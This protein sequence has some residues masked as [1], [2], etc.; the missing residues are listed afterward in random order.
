M[1]VIVALTVAVSGTAAA[2]D[3]GFKPALLPITVLGAGALMARRRWP[4][5][6]LAVVTALG[7]VTVALY[8]VAAGF[9][10]G[11]A[12]AVY[13]VAVARPVRVAWT[14]LAASTAPLGIAVLVRAESRDRIPALTSLGVML[15]AAIAIGISVRNRRLHLTE[16]VERGNALA[17]ESEQRSQLATAAERARIS[18]E[19]HDV[20]AHSLSVM[21]ALADGASA[22]LEKAPAAASAALE[23]LSETGRAALADMRRVLGVL[24]DG[25]A[26]FDPAPGGPDLD[27]LVQS[28]RDA[29]MPVRLQVS[30]TSLPTDTG[31][32]LAVYRIVQ[33]SLTNALRHSG[34]SGP[35]TAVVAH[36]PGTV[37]IE[38]TSPNAPADDSAGP[39][40]ATASVIRSTPTGGR[41][42]IGMRERA[43]IYGGAVDAGP[44]S[45]GWRVHADLHWDE[46]GT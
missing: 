16:L 39:S 32:Q 21:V 29:G 8:S 3:G 2:F 46:E 40:S 11:V 6:V 45:L 12:F 36:T 14:N 34:G 10:L 13:A 25:D 24:R 26:S 1:D 22:S 43:A 37:M 19:M 23:K 38:V 15:L 5:A 9:D 41:G 28:Y 20:V 27:A 35:V 17:R 44:C 31:L 18:R 4:V 33:E 7:I 30:G 42:I